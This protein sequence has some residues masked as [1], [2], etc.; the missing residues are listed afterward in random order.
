MSSVIYV[1]FSRLVDHFVTHAYTS[2]TLSNT[3]MPRYHWTHLKAK[4]Q[5]WNDNNRG[6]HTTSK[7]TFILREWASGEVRLVVWRRWGFILGDSFFS[8]GGEEEFCILHSPFSKNENLIFRSCLSPLR[9]C[10][11][12]SLPSFICDFLLLPT[13]VPVQSTYSINTSRRFILHARIGPK[14]VSQHFHE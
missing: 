8:S 12:T 1:H 10:A 14:G 2:I 4:C 7:S 5:M 13:S 3:L 11:F 6:S 9:S